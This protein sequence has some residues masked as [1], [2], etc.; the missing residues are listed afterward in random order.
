MSFDE[1]TC[2]KTKVNELY[3]VYV[4]PPV[5]DC[6][7]KSGEKGMHGEKGIPGDVGPKGDRGEKGE[8]GKNA[9]N[10][11]IFHFSLKTVSCV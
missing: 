7:A 8:Q 6:D 11:V 3:P 4:L 1:K 9:L 10:S 2:Q 5:T